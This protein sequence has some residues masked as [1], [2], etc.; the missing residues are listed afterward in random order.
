VNLTAL[1]TEKLLPQNVEAEACVLGS[2]VIDPDALTR[3]RDLL[4]YQDFYRDAHR[5]IYQAIC[6]LDDSGV[7]ADYITLCDELQRRGQLDAIGG[8]SYVSAL[9]NQVPTSA[10]IVSYARIVSRV[11]TLRRLIDAGGKIAGAA[12]NEP[13]ADVALNIAQDLIDTV[14]A[15]YRAAEQHQ[16]GPQSLQSS[17]SAWLNAFALA[18]A[19]QDSGLLSDEVAAAQAAQAPISTGLRSLD[20]WLRG[21]MKRGNLLTVGATPAQGKTALALTI[22]ANVARAGGRVLVFSLEMTT[23]ELLT[24]LISQVSRVSQDVLQQPAQMGVNEEQMAAIGEACGALADWRLFVD[25]TPALT[26]AELAAR[27]RALALREEGGL[28]L[29]VVDY[30]QLVQGA[31]LGDRQGQ[32]S[33]RRSDTREQEVTSVSHG[34]KA[35]A[36]LLDV[37]VLALAQVNDK[38]VEGRAD[39]RPLGSDYRE[40]SA[41]YHDSDVAM[42]LYRDAVYHPDESEPGQAELIFRKNRQ[43]ASGT[44]GLYFD[45]AHTWFAGLA[46]VQPESVG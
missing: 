20:H 37:P 12:Y 35:L 46:T 16:R 39:K 44:C 23:A 29:I 4:S 31:S 3:V 19:A 42:M 18:M 45:A 24:R 32:S 1:E 8:G 41:I 10:N 34:L 13:D 38:T 36:K 6:D 26:I 9:T 43:G 28:D 25:E 2:L 27:A 33:F 17:I 5:T 11:A 21:G 15:S 40:S 14:R 22:A 30:L 7:T